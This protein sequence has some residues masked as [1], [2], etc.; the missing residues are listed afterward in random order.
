MFSSSPAAGPVVI[1]PVRPAADPGENLAAGS[2][3]GLLRR[4]LG[5]GTYSRRTLG[6]SGYSRRTLGKSSYSRRTL[7]R[8]NPSRRTFGQYHP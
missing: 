7:G 4:T 3:A 6:K 5:R 1:I 8:Q 2:P